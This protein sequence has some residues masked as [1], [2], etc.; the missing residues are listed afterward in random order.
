MTLYLANNCQKYALKVIVLVKN[1]GF[2][3]G[4][5]TC[6]VEKTPNLGKNAKIVYINNSP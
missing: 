1:S 2:D 3:N 6:V 4:T 5:I